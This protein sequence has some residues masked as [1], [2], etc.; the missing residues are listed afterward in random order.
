MVQALLRSNDG[1]PALLRPVGTVESQR[2]VAMKP[3]LRRLLEDALWCL[4]K[5]HPVYGGYTQKLCKRIKTALKPV[6]NKRKS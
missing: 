3:K 6:S 4:E 5:G 2:I 1:L